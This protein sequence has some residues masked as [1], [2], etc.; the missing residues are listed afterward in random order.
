VLRSK[1]VDGAR[2]VLINWATGITVWLVLMGAFFLGAAVGQIMHAGLNSLLAHGI[3][4][5]RA[6]MVV[7]PIATIG[8]GLSRLSGSPLGAAVVVL[9]LL[10]VMAGLQFV[11]QFLR[12]DYTQNLALYA[13]AA[14]VLLALA[15]PLVERWRRG[16][17]RRPLLPA[18][19]LALALILATGGGSLA[20]RAAQPPKDGSVNE[21]MSHQYLEREKRVPGFWLPDGRG[22]TVRTADHEGKILFIYLFGGDDLE[23]ARSLRALDTLQREAGARGVQALGVCLSTDRADG[24][25]LSWASGLSF[26]IGADPTALRT[27]SSAEGSLATA[28]NLQTLPMLVVTDR[29]RRAREVFTEP[30]YDVDR[31]RALLNERLAEEPDY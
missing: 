7:V 6:A 20:Y 16:E 9:A 22:G 14:L 31:L 30:S 19:G 21:M 27:A 24:A 29:R 18:A 8:F 13:G 2:W 28:Y 23:A 15:G 17:L 11:P 10:C 26:P 12:P 1:P 3:G 4:F 5:V 25:A